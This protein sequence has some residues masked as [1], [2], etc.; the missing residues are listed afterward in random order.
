MNFNTRTTGNVSTQGDT[1]FLG[2]FIEFDS[3]TELGDSQV[4]NNNP[5]FNIL[6]NSGIFFLVFIVKN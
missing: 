1:S 3:F 2:G 4:L 5:E 6:V